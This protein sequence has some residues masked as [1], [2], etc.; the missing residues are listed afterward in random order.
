MAK[1]AKIKEQRQKRAH[2][3]QEYLNCDWT[4]DT[5]IWMADVL[6]GDLSSH[7]VFFHIFNSD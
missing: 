6:G 1:M 4:S 7:K 2:S 5:K 3:R